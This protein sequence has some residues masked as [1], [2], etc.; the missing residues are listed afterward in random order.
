MNRTFFLLAA[1]LLCEG[2]LAAQAQTGVTSFQQ[3]QSLGEPVGPIGG[4]RGGR[5][6]NVL[7]IPRAETGRPFSAIATTQTTQTLADGIHLSQTTTMA[8]Y[9]DAEGRVRTEISEAGASNSQPVKRITIRDPVAGATYTLDPLTKTARKQAT[10]PAAG[11]SPAGRGG[12]R[13]G[14]GDSTPGSNSD[15]IARMQQMVSDLQTLTAAMREARNNPNHLEEDLGTKTVNGVPVR[16]TRITTV[17]PVGAIGNDKE[18][19]SVTERWFSPDLNLLIKS[20]STDP[21]F[22]TTTYELTNINRQS[23]EASLFQVPADYSIVSNGR[24]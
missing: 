13:R 18:F 19:R 3:A 4:G 20:V 15:A 22:G 21:R 9:R 12:G 6:V 8:Q 1:G 7:P 24:Q 14:G 23:P 17:V 10:T 16:G 11:A 5:G 2:V